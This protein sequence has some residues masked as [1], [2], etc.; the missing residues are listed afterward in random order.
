ME[1]N[2]GKGS[3]LDLSTDL[4]PG[5]FMKPFLNTDMCSSIRVRDCFS[6]SVEWKPQAYIQI[7]EGPSL[8]R[9]TFV[10]HAVLNFSLRGEHIHHEHIS[11]ITDLL[12]AIRAAF[13]A[14]GPVYYF[15]FHRIRRS[16]KHHWIL[17]TKPVQSPSHQ[18]RNCLLNP[19]HRH[20]VAV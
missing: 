9:D 10:S 4:M 15:E 14:I 3:W 12:D 20:H 17:E 5:S 6:N 1:K 19:P 7:M 11:L 18:F 2:I 13:K 16:T 8:C